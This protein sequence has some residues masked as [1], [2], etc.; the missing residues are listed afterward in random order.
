MF[1]YLSHPNLTTSPF[2]VLVLRLGQQ[3]S[4]NK[5]KLKLPISVLSRSAL[6]FARERSGGKA[7]GQNGASG[8]EREREPS[9]AQSEG[10]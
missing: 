8:G 10:K 4:T 3:A 9:K 2:Y 5:V 7:H 6:A 1:C